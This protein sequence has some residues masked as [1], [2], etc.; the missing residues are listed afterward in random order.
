MPALNKV[1]LIGYLCAEPELRKTANGVS[2]CA[3]RIGVARKYKKENGE[4]ISDFISC[5]AWR[6]TAE[7]ICRNMKKGAAI[8]IVGSLQSRVY[9][10]DNQKR[11]ITEVAVE[12]VGF[13]AAKGSSSA[14]IPEAPP[15]WGK[16]NED[17]A[18]ISSPDFE[19]AN[20]TPLADDED[21]PY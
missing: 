8:Q 1:I 21:L 15:E 10:A 9:E 5:I 13:G 12:E 19:N 17:E 3:F 16:K 7:F 14:P 18:G 11:Y 2:A 20:F 6:S 4:S